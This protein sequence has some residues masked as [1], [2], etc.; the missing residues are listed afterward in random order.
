MG[1][2]NGASSETGFMLTDLARDDVERQAILVPDGPER[3]TQP[4]TRTRPT[5]FLDGLRGLAAL[6]VYMVHH[7]SWFYPP[8][9]NIYHGFDYHGEKYFATLPFV[10]F[11]LTGGSAAVAIFFV[12]SGYVLSKSPLNVLYN[13]GVPQLYRNL[14]SA[15][16]RRP[17]RLFMPPAGVSL[18][19]ALIMQ[20][21]FGLAPRFTWPVAKDTIFAELANWFVELCHALNPFEKHG[22]F[23]K[24]FPYDPPV[25]TMPVE[26][27]GS[28]LVF[29]LIAASSLIKPRYRSPPLIFLGLCFLFFYQWAM[30]CFVAGMVL[31]LS[32]IEESGDIILER[33]RISRRARPFVYYLSFILGWYLLCQIAGTKDPELS[34]NTL[35][36]YWLTMLTPR[37]YYN[38]EYWRFWLSIGAVLLVFAVLRLQWLQRF[39]TTPA[40]RYLGKISFSLYLTHIPFLWII[41]DRIYRIFGAIKA[42]SNMQ[43][44]FDNRLT[45]P[46][47]GPRGLSLRFIV[48][49]MFILFLNILL[50]HACTTFL[51]EPSVKFSRWIVT[52]LRQKAERQP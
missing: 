49:Q 45:I 7:L 20:L 9:D 25:W 4:N 39:L 19:V 36:W 16:V 2:G 31:A 41:G 52:R 33:W 32:D 6:V 3:Q 14:L 43:T 11:F 46:D 21:P 37:N 44:W 24:W 26:F 8:P 35:G 15:T 10:R 17:F 22:I 12:L 1:H 23:E 48:S 30:A 28:M 18:A 5:A 13:G 38:N 42:D 50:S 29:A 34:Y 47:V 40:L 27:E 51:D